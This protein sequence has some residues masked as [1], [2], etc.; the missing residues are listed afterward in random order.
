MGITVD[1]II[2]NSLS[3]AHPEGPWAGEGWRVQTKCSA[4]P[5]LTQAECEALGVIPECWKMTCKKYRSGWEESQ[6]KFLDEYWRLL[7]DEEGVTAKEAK[8]RAVAFASGRQAADDDDFAEGRNAFFEFIEVL[9]R[10]WDMNTTLLRFMRDANADPFLVSGTWGALDEK[11]TFKVSFRI[12]GGSDKLTGFVQFPAQNTVAGLTA[13]V[14]PLRRQFF[15]GLREGPEYNF[16]TGLIT[17]LITWYWDKSRQSVKRTIEKY[18]ATKTQ[19]T[20]GMQGKSVHT[21]PRLR[22]TTL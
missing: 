9:K 1:S 16:A 4:P 22:L 13:L 18:R 3:S 14:I 2:L 19:Y 20:N 7:A 17:Q 6:R 15:D 8:S 12:H 21:V 10:R 11:T 5:W